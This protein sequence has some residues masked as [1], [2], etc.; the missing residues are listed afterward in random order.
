MQSYRYRTYKNHLCRFRCKDI[1][2]YTDN[3]TPT[4]SMFRGVYISASTY[5]LHTT[6]WIRDG[7]VI[8]FE[9]TKHY[10]LDSFSTQIRSKVQYAFCSTKHCPCTCNFTFGIVFIGLFI[11]RLVIFHWPASHEL[12]S[13]DFR[14]ISELYISFSIFWKQRAVR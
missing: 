12:P 14:E 6:K 1:S 11:Q 3:I 7:T 9:I 5:P 4:I 2:C 10:L 8:P 13:L